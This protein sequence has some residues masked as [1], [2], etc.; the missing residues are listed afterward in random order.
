MRKEEERRKSERE[1]R[2]EEGIRARQAEREEKLA[3][4]RGK[5]ERTMDM[6]RAIARERFG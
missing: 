6:L 1:V 2:R 3:A 4:L 5:E